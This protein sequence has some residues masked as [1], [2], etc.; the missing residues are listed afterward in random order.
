MLTYETLLEL[1]PASVPHLI[2]KVANKNVLIF[3]G[4]L[5]EIKRQKQRINLLL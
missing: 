3:F 4:F 5:T 2:V 1:S